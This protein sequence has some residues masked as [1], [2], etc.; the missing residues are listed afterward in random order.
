MAEKRIDFA[1]YNRDGGVL[2]GMDR[3]KTQKENAQNVKNRQWE[4]IYGEQIERS[5]RFEW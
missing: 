5:V 4:I 1:P 2:D 3:V